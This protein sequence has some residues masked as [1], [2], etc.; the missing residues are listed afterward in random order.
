MHDEHAMFLFAQLAA[1]SAERQ[2]RSGRDRF[3]IL[4]GIAATRAGWP[5]VAAR[6]HELVATSAPHHLLTKYSSFAA[7]LR[8]ADFTAFA[9]QLKKFCTP[10]RAEHLLTELSLPTDAPEPSLSPGTATLE[11]LNTIH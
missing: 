9:A 1:V 2:Q 6:C 4:A 7:A 11:V 10:E 5:D 3:L 8:D